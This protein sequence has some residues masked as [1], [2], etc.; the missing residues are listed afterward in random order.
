MKRELNQKRPLHAKRL[1]RTTAYSLGALLLAL[2]SCS[3]SAQESNPPPSAAASN[4]P[5]PVAGGAATNTVPE[6]ILNGRWQRP[7]GG[8]VID[9]RSPQGN[10]KLEA[11]YFNPR[12]INVS[13]SE[14]SR[15]EDGLHVFVELRDQ[16]YPGATYKLRYMPD[17]DQLA[18][19]YY[20]PLH[21]QSFEVSFIRQSQ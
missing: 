17:K 11:Y 6:N 20:Q 14:W 10:G 15:K 21:G 3:K 2:A 7:D 8:Y 1:Q 13:K 12:P 9:I 5:V 19:D 18:G 4:A 16:N